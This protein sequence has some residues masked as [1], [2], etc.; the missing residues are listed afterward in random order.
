[1]CRLPGALK[2][3]LPCQCPPSSPSH[4]AYCAPRCLLPSSLSTVPR[5]R[6][7]DTPDGASVVVAARDQRR[8]RRCRYGCRD[9][10]GARHVNAGRQNIAVSRKR[11]LVSRITRCRHLRH[12]FSPPRLPPPRK[13]DWLVACPAA[14]LRVRARACLWRCA[15]AQRHRDA[16]VRPFSRQPVMKTDTTRTPGPHHTCTPSP[17]SNLRADT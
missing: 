11:R 6:P 8:Q 16:C 1:M 7:P 12:A 15:C 13:E 2:L 10:D 4:P 5:P 3:T 14:L 17:S 9:H